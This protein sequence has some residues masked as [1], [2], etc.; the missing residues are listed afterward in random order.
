MQYFVKLLLLGL[1]NPALLFGFCA[2]TEQPP[3]AWK[4]KELDNKPS[5]LQYTAILN[6][7]DKDSF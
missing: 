7:S 1:E 5:I 3:H 6:Q 4:R 2:P